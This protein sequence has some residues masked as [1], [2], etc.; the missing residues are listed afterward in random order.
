MFP[1]NGCL[2]HWGFTYN[3]HFHNQSVLVFLKPSIVLLL[4]ATRKQVRTLKGISVMAIGHGKCTGTTSSIECN[5]RSWVYPL[6]WFFLATHGH[7]GHVSTSLQ[8]NVK[9]S[10]I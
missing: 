4:G 6:H 2:G 1:Y 9:C 5:K 10:N 8:I 3:V 7:I